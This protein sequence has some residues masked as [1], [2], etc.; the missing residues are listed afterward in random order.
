MGKQ[1]DLC[2]LDQPGGTG[3]VRSSMLYPLFLLPFLTQWGSNATEV[4]SAEG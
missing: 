1:I 2:P 4:E 3:Q